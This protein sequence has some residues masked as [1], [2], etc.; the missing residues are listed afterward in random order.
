MSLIYAEITSVPEILENRLSCH[1]EDGFTVIAAQHPLLNLVVQAL[2]LYSFVEVLS[3]LC[4]RT[5]DTPA[6]LKKVR[7]T[8]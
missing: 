4:D 8:R 6:L 5:P 7:A 1:S 2:R 3:A